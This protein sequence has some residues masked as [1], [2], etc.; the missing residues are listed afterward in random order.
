MREHRAFARVATTEQE[1]SAQA[2]LVRRSERGTSDPPPPHP[3]PPSKQT[4]EYQSASSPSTQH[5]KPRDILLLL[6]LLLSSQV[7]PVE[8]AAATTAPVCCAPTPAPAR[9]Q[10]QR[11]L[12]DAPVR[13][14]VVCVSDMSCPAERP[15][16]RRDESRR[17]TKPGLSRERLRPTFACGVPKGCQQNFVCFQ[18]S[19][20]SNSFDWFG[21]SCSAV[22]PYA[23]FRRAKDRCIGKTTWASARPMR[24]R[25]KAVFDTLRRSTSRAF[26]RRSQTPAQAR[27]APPCVPRASF[28]DLGVGVTVP[29]N[30][31]CYVLF[32][33]CLISP[34]LF[35]LLRQPS[36]FS[37]FLIGA[38]LPRRLYLPPT[39]LSG[40][41]RR[42]SC[43][44]VSLLLPA[45]KN[46]ATTQA[47]PASRSFWR[48]AR[49]ELGVAAA[50][51][52]GRRRPTNLGSVS[53]WLSKSKI[54]A[55]QNGFTMGVL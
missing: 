50:I 46:R 2:P 7:P 45:G 38:R 5:E 4:D 29:R 53:L 11:R 14:V 35:S 37:I 10:Q 39:I 36:L 28:S 44:S 18:T 12:Q 20:N 48:C 30:A 9:R 51:H 24:T 27:S 15:F 55:Q 31:T 3:A 52:P 49:P 54:G 25:K 40:L 6:L 47:S 41:R 32:G 22:A 13:L 43:Y 21:A 19:R 8:P 16:L 26:W 42:V 23:S 17:K 1:E 33:V 34:S